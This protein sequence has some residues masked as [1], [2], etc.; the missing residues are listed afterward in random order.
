[1]LHSIRNLQSRR[2]K[3]H[4]AAEPIKSNDEIPRWLRH[5]PQGRSLP[6]SVQGHFSDAILDRWVVFT[7]PLFSPGSNPSQRKGR[8]MAVAALGF[9]RFYIQGETIRSSSLDGGSC[10]Y[11][12]I[13]TLHHV[14]GCS[15][16]LYKGSSGSRPL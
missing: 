9:T 1:M 11:R 2:G 3:G 16:G 4:S 7:L 14:P 10:I 6:P 5:V 8:S 13:S 15:L 12:C